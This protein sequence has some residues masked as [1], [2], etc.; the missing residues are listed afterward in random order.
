MGAVVKRNM[1]RSEATTLYSD[2]SPDINV[3]CDGKILK[4]AVGL[5]P[6]AVV[7]PLSVFLVLMFAL[8]IVF[9]FLWLRFSFGCFFY[10]LDAD[11]AWLTFLFVEVFFLYGIALSS[12]CVIYLVNVI[13]P[14]SAEIHID[15]KTMIYGNKLWR[16]KCDLADE[17]SLLVEPGYTRGDWGFTLQIVFGGRKHLFLPNVF[18]GSYSEAISAARKLAERIQECIGCPRIDESKYWRYH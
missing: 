1:A 12:W 8:L 2:S 14:Y 16:R 7:I 5:M 11:K 15:A 6:L 18:V 9:S 10:G 3:S 17:V 4:A 13:L